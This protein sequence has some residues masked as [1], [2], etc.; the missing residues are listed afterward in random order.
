MLGAVVDIVIFIALGAH[1][2]RRGHLTGDDAG[3]VRAVA[4][5]VHLGGPAAG[6][7]GEVQV[8]KWRRYVQRVVDPEVLVCPVDAGIDDRPYDVGS[9]RSE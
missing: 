2:G 8:G 5:V 3:H 7:V 4:V 1:D 9:G 6:Q